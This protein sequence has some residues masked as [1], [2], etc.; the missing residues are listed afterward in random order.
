MPGDCRTSA[1]RVRAF[2]RFYTQIMG[3]LDPHHEGLD[4]TLA[5]A[6]ILI[7][8]SFSPAIEVG[9]LAEALQLESTFTSRTLSVLEDR[10]L[11]QRSISARD[12]RARTVQL[13]TAGS[14]L[15]TEL[16]SR[17]NTRVER[18]L[19]HLT[20]SQVSELLDAMDVIEN[21]LDPENTTPQA[22]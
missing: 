1:E 5:Q 3:S 20:A 19:S 7:T 15:L 11:V 8:V 13:S 4:L 12:R 16:I 2:N 9:E 18:L 10:G 21:L 6:R 14:E 22:R 17:S